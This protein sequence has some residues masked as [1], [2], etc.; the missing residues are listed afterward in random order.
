MKRIV[1]DK[2]AWINATGE[3]VLDG[4]VQVVPPSVV[5]LEIPEHERF[6]DPMIDA[7]RELKEAGYKLA[8]DDFRYRD[9]SEELLGLLDVVKLST[10]ELGRHQMLLYRPGVVGTRGIGANRRALLQVVAALNDPSVEYSQS[11]QLISRDVA[12]SFRLLRYVN[13]AYFGL[14]DDVR[15]IGQALLRAGRCTARDREFLRAV[16]ARVVLGDRLDDGRADARRGRLA[17]PRRG[18]ERGAQ[19]AQRADGPAARLRHLARDWRGRSRDR[20]RRARRRAAPR[21]ADVG[22]HGR[23]IAVR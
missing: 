7:L 5:G 6:D 9:G 17:S 15:S 19:P 12:L 18:H 3:F 4:L 20:E 11:E 1:A 22:Q 21:G 10:P 2:K 16:H 23:R 13:S 14:R 8:L